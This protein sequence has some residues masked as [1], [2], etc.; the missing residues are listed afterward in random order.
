MLHLYITDCF[1]AY[2]CKIIAPLKYF[3]MYVLKH[4]SNT[5]F[6][7]SL[8]LNVAVAARDYLACG[9]ANVYVN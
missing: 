7:R 3:V 6:I 8:F 4:K 1:T 2:S 5:V 9:A